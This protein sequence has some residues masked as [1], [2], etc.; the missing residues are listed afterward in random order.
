MT[1][2]GIER[3]SNKP[4][5]PNMLF[6]ELGTP[7]EKSEEALRVLHNKINTLSSPTEKDLE[8]VLFSN[9]HKLFTGIQKK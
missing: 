7:E 2:L 5:A 8:K 1:H 6:F 4:G 9:A 3:I